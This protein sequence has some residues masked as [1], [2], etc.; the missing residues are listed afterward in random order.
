[1][2]GQ[3]TPPLQ[4]GVHIYRLLVAGWYPKQ[5][6]KR[7]GCSLALVWKYAK[8][9]EGEGKIER[10][11]KYP[12]IWRIKKCEIHPDMAGTTYT[13]TPVFI[14]HR[15][16]GSF[17][18][19]GKP[20]LPYDKGGFA[21]IKDP[22]FTARLGRSKAVIWL[23]SFTGTTVP[24]QILN[25][26]QAILALAEKLQHD[27]AITLTFD[28]W[29][30]GIDW[31]IAEKKAGKVIGDAAGLKEEPKVIAGAEMV[32]DDSTHKDLLEVRPAT[33]NSPTRATEVAKTLEYLITKAPLT[34]AEIDKRL[35]MQEEAFKHVAEYSR[36]IELH[37]EVETRTNE[38]LE[39]MN[40]TLDDIRNSLKKPKD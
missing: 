28:R 13:P 32:F 12:A 9:Y 38:V 26:R 2:H 22:A 39:K 37:L 27:Y 36:N 20:R 5:I 24:E 17:R 10:T 8:R 33:N 30:E 21:T 6:A 18:L 14:P 3:Y 15:L 31:V 11:C 29:F 19:I 40:Q 7:V 25:G 4:K 35:E 34:L 23:K 1:M 16:G